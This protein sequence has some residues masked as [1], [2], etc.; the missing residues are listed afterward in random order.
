ML[1]WADA[2]FV[3]FAAASVLLF[4]P[5]G[6]QNSGG[7]ASGGDRETSG[8]NSSSTGEDGLLG[9]FLDKEKNFVRNCEPCGG[10]MPPKKQQEP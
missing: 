10:F 5:I 9:R 7:G 3:L 6:A 4:Q 8:S 1:F 2:Y